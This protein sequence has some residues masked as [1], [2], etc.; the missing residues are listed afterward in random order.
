[1]IQTGAVGLCRAGIFEAMYTHD[2]LTPSA[3][4]QTRQERLFRLGVEVFHDPRITAEIE[5]Q[6][7]S[8]LTAQQSLALRT[9]EAEREEQRLRVVAKNF[10]RRQLA[11]M[12]E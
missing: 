4:Q 11:L 7:T 10:E 8:K 3:I 9:I 2:L 12:A 5:A 6:P 1:M